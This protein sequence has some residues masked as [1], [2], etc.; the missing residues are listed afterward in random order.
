MKSVIVTVPSHSD[1]LSIHVARLLY[2]P[3]NEKM[4]RAEEHFI[5]QR[6]AIGYNHLKDKPEVKL[7]MA[8]L[9]EYRHRLKKLRLED[10][11]VNELYRLA[12]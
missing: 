10:S 3:S 2:I 12:F 4:S 1:L 7:L 5:T 8:D 9:K 11:E 6:L